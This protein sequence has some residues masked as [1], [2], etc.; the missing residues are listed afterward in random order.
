MAA[1][2]FDVTRVPILLSVFESVERVASANEKGSDVSC[3]LRMYLRTSVHVKLEVAIATR[4]AGLAAA[5]AA[6]AG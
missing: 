3:D 2:G 1:G 4:I 5:V 6:V